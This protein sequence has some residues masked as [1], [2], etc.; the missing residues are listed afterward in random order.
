M[1]KIKYWLIPLLMLPII[2]TN[3]AKRGTI[4]GG[5]KDTLAP[6]M[7]SSNPSNYSKNFKGNSIRLNFDEYIKLKDANKQIIVSPPLKNNLII[8]PNGSASK[9]I[10]ITFKDTLQDN[11][12]YTINFGQSIEDNNEGNPY[13]AF[14]YVFSTG[15]YIDSLNFKG[16]VNDA[17]SKTVDKNISVMLYPV[18]NFTDSTI[19][20]KT[21]LY[22]TNTLEYGSNFEIDNIKKGTYY[23]I[24]LK[25]E[26]KNNLFDPKIDKIAFYPK[27]VS[28]PT[29]TLVNLNLFKEEASFEVRKPIQQSQNKVTFGL[30]IL[31]YDDFKVENKINNKPINTKITKVGDKDSIAIWLPKLDFKEDSLQISIKN[32]NQDFNQKLKLKNFKTTDTL[33]IVLNKSTNLDFRDSYYIKVSTPIEKLDATKFLFTKKDSTNFPFKLNLLNLENKIAVDFE[34]LE[35]EKFNL[36]ILPGAITDFYGKINDTLTA[37]ILTKKHTEYGNL[38]LVVNNAKHSKYIVQLLDD[39]ENIKYEMF[40]EGKNEYYFVDILPN[41]YVVRIVYDMDGNKKWTPGDYLKKRLPEEVIYFPQLIDVRANW[42]V[43]QPI[44]L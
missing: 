31:N 33:Q 28:I 19:Y 43:N 14:K 32:R 24:A 42:D 17:L 6:V 10:N 11:T 9:F 20:K 15:E 34:K 5:A 29:D 37:N 21:P 4:T 26:N 18:E 23:A 39:K 44:D 38:N 7:T 12:T 41:K 35:D 30:N 22:V 1:L 3:C 36:T 13:T 25:D 27:K 8:T 40:S 2:L 16:T